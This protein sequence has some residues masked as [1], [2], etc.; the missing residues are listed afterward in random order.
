M[1]TLHSTMPPEILISLTVPS[2]WKAL[3]LL[4]CDADG[5][6]PPGHSMTIRAALARNAFCTDCRMTDLIE[7]AFDVVAA[8]P[9]MLI[10]VEPAATVPPELPTF[11]TWS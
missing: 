4:S 1:L 7:L 11:L 10:Y 3:T 2:T 9:P 5:V 6:P 8:M